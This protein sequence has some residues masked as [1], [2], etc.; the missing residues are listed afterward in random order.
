MVMVVLKQ[1]IGPILLL[2]FKIEKSYL[3][4]VCAKCLKDLKQRI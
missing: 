4:T 3:A 1:R 2:F